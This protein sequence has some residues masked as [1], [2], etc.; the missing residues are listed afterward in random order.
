M[1]RT[2]FRIIFATAR[3]MIAFFQV[4]L[5]QNSSSSVLQSDVLCQACSSRHGTPH[6]NSFFERCHCRGT[7]EVQDINIPILCI[8]SQVRPCVTLFQ[9]DLIMFKSISG[10]PRAL[11]CRISCQKTICNLRWP[12]SNLHILPKPEVLFQ[13]SGWLHVIAE[14]GRSMDWQVPGCIRRYCKTLFHLGSQI[15]CNCQMVNICIACNVSPRNVYFSSW[16]PI[17]PSL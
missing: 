6:K 5:D 12:P 1:H 17:W 15:F 3:C 16:A 7:P 14:F 13:A 10:V 4:I 11:Q 8:E 9:V 2:R